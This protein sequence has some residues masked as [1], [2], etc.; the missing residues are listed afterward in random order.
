[1]NTLIAVPTMDQVPAQFAQCLSMLEKVDACAVSFNVGS[2]IYSSRNELAKRAI[3]MGADYVFWL[4]SD[5]VFDTD[6]LKRCFADLEHG[7]IVTGLYFRRVPP[8]TPV[9]YESLDFNEDGGCVWKEYCEIPDDIFEVAACGFG[10][11]L[12]PTHIFVDVYS[13]FNGAIFNPING[14]GEDLSFCWRARQ[15][16]FKIVCDPKISLG[17]VGYQTVTRDYYEAFKEAKK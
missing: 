6:T 4:D 8:F 9:I 12:M 1:M 2:L 15:R 13:N 16:G 5:M 7:D 10:C 14:T 11:V 3:Q 17:H